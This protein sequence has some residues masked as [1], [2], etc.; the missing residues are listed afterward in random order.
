MIASDGF[1]MHSLQTTAPAEGF[2]LPLAK[3][4]GCSRT[5]IVTFCFPNWI[6]SARLSIKMSILL[7]LIAEPLS[8][9][10]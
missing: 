1:R 9:T 6:A 8:E 3:I 7:P 10:V 2:L 4:A 5:S